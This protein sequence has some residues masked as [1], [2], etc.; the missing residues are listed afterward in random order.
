[1]CVGYFENTFFLP[2]MLLQ[3]Y[4]GKYFYIFIPIATNYNLL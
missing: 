3:N 2:R 1:M 4:L